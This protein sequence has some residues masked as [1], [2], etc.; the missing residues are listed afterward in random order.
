MNRRKF[1]S[2]SVAASSLFLAKS[3]WAN[4]IG[5][6]SDIRLGFAGLGNMG[7]HHVREFLKIPGVRTVA[8]CDADTDHLDRGLA[9]IE[10]ENGTGARKATRTF[11]DYRDFI[12]F[13]EIDAVVIA[14]PNHW[15]TL[16]AVW[17]MKKGKDV[18]L[19]K[20]LSH[21]IT[22][23]RYLVEAQKKYGRIVQHGTQRRCDFRIEAMVRY[24]KSGQLGKIKLA[25]TISY[26]QRKSI[27]NSKQ[28]TALP[29]TV[30]FDHWCGPAKK[31]P[32]MRDRLHYDWHWIWNTGNGD[33]GNNGVHQLDVCNWVTGDRKAAPRVIS[34][35]G[36]FGYDDHGQV[37]N[38]HIAYFDYDEMPILAEVRGL[39]MTRG[40]G[41]MPH[42]LT[43]RENV[44]IHCEGGYATETAI[45]DNQ[46]ERMD[47][48]ETEPSSNVRNNFIEAVRSG[49]YSMIRSR[50]DNGHNSCTLAHQANIS[51][52][53]GETQNPNETIER[54]K[55]N[56]YL[57]ESYGRMTEHLGNNGVYLTQNPATIGAWLS[58]DSK[59]ERFVGASSRKANA[60]LTREYRAPYQLPAIG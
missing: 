32:I 45:F 12:E 21:N 56:P 11:Q 55:G 52:R 22:E 50:I 53:I 2:S 44:I 35:G 27:G 39:E 18:Y 3:S 26:K 38:T 33:I 40:S 19:E 23:G 51:Y 31:D 58:Y 15:H 47:V 20:P 7:S 42:Y 59:N 46:G 5:A 16:M 37:P 34:L 30:D 1:I 60:L 57:T 4:V 28:P 10:K 49:K 29:K 14:S 43:Q 6:S 9:I 17:A 54:I 25:H 41:Q 13:E 8:L 36:R 48:L 24:V